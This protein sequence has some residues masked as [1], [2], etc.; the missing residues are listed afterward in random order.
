MK[1]KLFVNYEIQ[2]F[3]LGIVSFNPYVYHLSRGSIVSTRA[4]NLLTHAFNLPTRAFNHATRAFSLLTREFELVTREFELVT[5]GFELVTCGFEL[6]T[7]NSCFYF[8]TTKQCL[9]HSYIWKKTLKFYR[10]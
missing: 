5:H 9:L 2:Y 8:S 6:V 1:I 4:F 3:E 7:R 10:K